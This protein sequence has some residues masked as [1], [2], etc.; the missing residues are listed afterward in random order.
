MYSGLNWC[1]AAGTCGSPP[2]AA[3]DWQR[4]T[5][6][7]P[8]GGDDATGGA[9]TAAGMFAALHLSE[10][11]VPAAS[12]RRA[13][14]TADRNPIIHDTALAATEHGGPIGRG[15]R[16]LCL[17]C[18]VMYALYRPTAR[19]QVG[20]ARGVGPARYAE[21]SGADTG[22]LQRRYATA[23]SSQLL[24]ST[25]RAT[26][27]KRGP[28][29]RLPLRRARVTSCG[30]CGATRTRQ[31]VTCSCPCACLAAEVKGKS[32]R[33]MVAVRSVSRPEVRWAG[34]CTVRNR[35]SG[36]RIRY[37]A[38]TR[39][40]RRWGA[41]ARN[42]RSPS[43]RQRPHRRPLRSL[44]TSLPICW[45]RGCRLWRRRAAGRKRKLPRRKR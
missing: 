32:Q 42:R 24:A 17:V 9:A 10:A 30:C 23:M 15:A 36:L 8:A 1:P 41:A 44:R 5:R 43:Q 7:A 20:T 31:K 13:A 21:V 6:R 22:W 2:L 16:S 4:S 19:G 33:E 40:A 18:L 28:S 12:A 39:P 26:I 3:L 14:P 35:R 38:S 11:P 45:A 25:L 29:Q 34:G 37:R 27:P